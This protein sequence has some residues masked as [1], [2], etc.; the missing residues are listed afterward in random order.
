M[1]PLLS[2]QFDIKNKRTFLKKCEYA[3]IQIKDIFMGAVLNILLKTTQ[4]C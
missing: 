1:V 3:G 4:S 2:I